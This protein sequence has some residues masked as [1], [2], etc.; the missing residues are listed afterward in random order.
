MTVMPRFLLLAFSLGLPAV[1]VPAVGF[2]RVARSTLTIVQQ[3]ETVPPAP[4]VN[5]QVEPSPSDLRVPRTPAA[6]PPVMQTEP[7]VAPP[8]A[9]MISETPVPSVAD[10]LKDSYNKHD[11][12]VCDL[13]STRGCNCLGEPWKLPQPCLLQRMGINVGGWL[14][15]GVT[16][17]TRKPADG[18]NGPVATN[19]EDTQYQMNQLWL[20]L[21]RPADTGG[22]GWAWGGRVDMLYGTDWRFGVNHGL[23]DRI[24]SLDGQRYGMVIPQAY[25]EVAY[26]DLSVKLGHFG[27]ILDYE[28]VP[29]PPNPFYS[30]SYSYGY[31]VPQLVTGV[32]ADWKMTDQWSVQAGVHRGWMM[33][34]DYNDDWDIMAG[35]KWASCSGNTSVAFA[36]SSGR[37][38]LR[39]VIEADDDN[40]FVYSLVIQQKLT[41]RLRYVLV[42]NL[43][44]ETG[45]PVG[46]GQE[47]DAEWYGL[48]QYLLY[49]I[50][51]CLAANLRA[52]WMRDDDGVRIAGPGNIDGISAWEGAGYAGNFYNLTAGLNWRPHANLLFRPE[53]RYDWYNGE[54]SWI[55]GKPARPFNAGASSDQWTIG[56]DMVITY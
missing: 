26:N 32:L 39:P 4:L 18:F 6:P 9:P 46:E 53:I 17:N 49:Q 50:N 21:V 55:P 5:D 29:A 19:D 30:H 12:G 38:S 45:F 27:A 47:I 14:Q 2:D 41:E 37:Q 16:Y 51:P 43:G 42:H 36:L 48:N 31:T 15:H 23:E 34:E 24:N 54:D 56:M 10:M 33:F 8:V 52:E 35:I 28:M 22:C 1:A 13:C 7:L 40:R 11:L 25:L 20:Y 44:Y 3:D